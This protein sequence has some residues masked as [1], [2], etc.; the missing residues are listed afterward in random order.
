[1]EF[2]LCLNLFAKFYSLHIY[3]NLTMKKSSIISADDQSLWHQYLSRGQ[4]NDIYFLPEYARLWDAIDGGRSYLFAYSDSDSYYIYPFRRCCLS[5]VPNLVD[6][7]DWYDIKSDYGYGGPLI[8]H[9]GK[10]NQA[11]FIDSAVRK[12]DEYCTSNNIVCEFCR[13]HP[14]FGNAQTVEKQYSPIFCNK[15]AWVNLEL[16]IDKIRAQLR[17][18][19]K[20]GVNKAEKSGVVIRIGKSLSDIHTF[21]DIYISAM[22]MVQADSYYFFSPEF[23]IDTIEK[24]SGNVVIFIADYLGEPVA[25]SMFLH[26]GDYCHY[27]FG[28]QIP[29]QSLAPHKLLMWKAIEWAKDRGY[30]KLHLGGGYGGSDN[31][32]LMFFKTGFTKLRADFFISKRVHNTEIYH[33]ACEKRHVQAGD[34]QGF[35]PAYR[36]L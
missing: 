26:R 16:P 2:G 28:G 15:T 33:K 29:Q 30:L 20:Y 5:Q 13:F 11:E 9:G 10:I 7:D 23:F 4:I 21:C 19:W 31:D 6:F 34:L 1:M 35:F 24:L 17:R 14:L 27:H 22:E 8:Y 12:F 25:A 32:S 18:S 3:G 36:K